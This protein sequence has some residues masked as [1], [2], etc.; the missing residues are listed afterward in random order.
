[1]MLLS[2]RIY[3]EEEVTEIIH[4]IVNKL[5]QHSPNIKL[6]FMDEKTMNKILIIYP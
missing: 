3:E 4:K 2:G 6:I 5:F 1:M